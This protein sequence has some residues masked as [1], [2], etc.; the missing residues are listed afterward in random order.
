MRKKMDVDLSIIIVSYKVPELLDDCLAS[1]FAQP[2]DLACEILV[3][4]N[5]PGDGSAEIVREKY[6]QVT[7]LEPDDNLGFAGGNNFA[8]RQATGRRLLLLNPD[9][10]VLDD[11]IGTLWAFA[12]SKPSAG[13]VGGRTVRKDGSLEPTCCW[14][15]PGLWPLLCKATALNVVMKGSRLFDR[16][17]MGWWQR[18]DDR[19]VDI[20]TGCFLMIDRSVWDEL[21]GF[22]PRFFMYAEEVDLCWRVRKT[23]REIWFAHEP[24][25]VHLVGASASKATGSRLLAVNGALL[26]L[27]YK[28]KGWVYCQIANILMIVGISIRSVGTGCVGLIRGGGRVGRALD[29]AKAAVAQC[30][31]LFRMR[32]VAGG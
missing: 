5:A 1:I 12:D 14:A 2:T 22:D 26:R 25:I 3:V 23:G 19:Q 30:A 15:D 21:G 10:I 11:A 27:F 17:A 28:H 31:W 7:L 16:E 13:I 29:L 20:I 32:K 24:E 9:T 6:P 4:D 18:D 8:A